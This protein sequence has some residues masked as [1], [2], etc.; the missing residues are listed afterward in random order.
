MKAPDPMRCKAN[1]RNGVRCYGWSMHGQSVCRMHGGS[2]PQALKKA[3]DRLRALEHPAISAM[4]QLIERGESEAIRFAVARWV[5]EVLGHK[6]TVQV[7]TEQEVVITIRHEEQ[8]I[9]VEQ[10]YHGAI[11]GRSHD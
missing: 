1:N 7:S 11:D 3:E 9:I 4:E 10:V 5:L 2:S 8:P 6:A